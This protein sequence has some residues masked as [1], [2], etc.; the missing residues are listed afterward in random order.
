MLHQ[1]SGRIVSI[2]N[3]PSR[4]HAA[5]DCLPDYDDLVESICRTQV[6]SGPSRPENIRLTTVF[7][8]HHQ[9]QQHQTKLAP[10][11]NLSSKE[12]AQR[13]LM[14]IESDQTHVQVHTRRNLFEFCSSNI[15]QLATF[16]L[17]KL[18]LRKSQKIPMK[19]Q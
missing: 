2:K 7:T 6:A 11:L 16:G 10:N 14:G 17:D 1:G 15:V 5:I 12:V 3:T 4:A 13:I 19:V 9:Q 8:N 18:Q